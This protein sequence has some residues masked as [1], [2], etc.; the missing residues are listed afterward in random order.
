MNDDEL[1]RAPDL[2][3][4]W[5]GPDPLGVSVARA[6]LMEAG[7]VNLARLV[8]PNRI[9]NPMVSDLAVHDASDL[10]LVARAFLLGHLAEGHDARIVTWEGRPAIHCQE[11]YERTIALVS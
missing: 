1:E 10:D 5:D 8:R 3:S 11:C 6:A 2:P 7:R 9:G 4:L